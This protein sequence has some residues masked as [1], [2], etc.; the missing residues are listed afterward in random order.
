MSTVQTATR[1]YDTRSHGIADT[2]TMLR[3]NLLHAKRYPGLAT[4]VVLMPI[5]LLLMFNY[6]FGGALKEA[7]G[8]AKYI[9]YLAPGM[10][11]MVPAFVC[12]GLAVMVASDMTKGIVS[13]FRSMSI[14]QSAMLNGQVIGTAIQALLG[15]I[16]MT[17]VAF[18]VGFRTNANPLE[19][20]A[21]LGLIVLVTIALNWLAVG[22]GL[23]AQT[24]ESAG[25]LPLPITMLPFLGSGLVPTDTMP[26]GVR[27]FAEYQP[28]SPI[29]ETLRG[30]LM[31]TEIGK[32]G[33]LA[34]AWCVALAVLG[35]LWSNAMFRRRA[36]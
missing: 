21:A 4:S 18:A 7:T 8:D 19:W 6:I 17:L 32:N 35:Y 22:I 30:L 1:T 26:A 2:K 5:I 11:L 28:F 16:A 34:I 15:V 29:T 10:M 25:N 23:I 14:S 24:P 31:G 12:A 13:R 33:I 3:R 20:L 27:Q 9:D 36:N